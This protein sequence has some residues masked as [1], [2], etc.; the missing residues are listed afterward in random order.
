MQDDMPFSLTHVETYWTEPRQ[1]LRAWF[2]RNAPSLGELYEGALRMFFAPEFPGR[3]RFVAHAVREIR[4]R[5]PDAIAGP[6]IGG[7]FQWINKLS[8]CYFLLGDRRYDP[9][10]HQ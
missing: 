3:V 9:A 4:N 5:L 10:L 2:Q 7:T 8:A 6:K 1:E